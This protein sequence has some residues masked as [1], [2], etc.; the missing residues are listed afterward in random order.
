VICIGTL[1]DYIL[2]NKKIKLDVFNKHT[3][4]YDKFV[5]DK[6]KKEKAIKES[7]ELDI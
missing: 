2:N 6:N 5:L 7:K 3:F 1:V 4:F